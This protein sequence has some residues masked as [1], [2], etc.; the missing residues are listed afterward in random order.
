[1]ARRDQRRAVFELILATLDIDC[2]R[3]F[4]M[5]A[6]DELTY[7]EMTEALNRGWGDL[8][9]RVPML[10]QQERSGVKIQVPMADLDA[11]LKSDG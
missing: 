6:F 5:I 9:S 2:R 7:A 3:L 11:V 4:Q 10:L 8:D 1:M